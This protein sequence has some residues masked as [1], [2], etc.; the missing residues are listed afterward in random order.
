MR[1]LLTN[2]NYKHTWIM[3]AHLHDL[4]HKIYCVS[5]SKFNFLSFSKF[6]E[7]VFICKNP[8]ERSY[9]DL[10]KKKYDR[11]YYSNWIQRVVV[12]I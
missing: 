7:K 4:G 9:E 3:A 12:I 6:I 2:P 10:C 8:S 11:D 1:V 5:E